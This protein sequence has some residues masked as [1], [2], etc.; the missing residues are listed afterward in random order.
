MIIQK[1]SEILLFFKHDG[2]T[3]ELEQEVIASNGLIELIRKVIRSE[4]PKA[5]SFSVSLVKEDIFEINISILKED[6]PW[7]V[8]N[9]TSK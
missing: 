3:L 8:N 1:T 4:Y 9:E 2:V 6:L 5:L 7:K